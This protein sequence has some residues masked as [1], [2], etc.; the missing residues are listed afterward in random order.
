MQDLICGVSDA[1]FSATSSMLNCLL[2]GFTAASTS[3]HQQTGAGIVTAPSNQE[4]AAMARDILKTLKSEHAELRSLF[5]QMEDTTDRAAKKRTDILRKIEDGLIPHAKWEEL[6][7]YP[8][9]KARADRDGLKT[10]SEAVQEH[11][12]VEVTVLPDLKKKDPATPDFAG[13][14]KVLGEFVKHHAKEEE[15]TMFSDAREMFSKDELAQFDEHY[16]AWKKS[17]EGKQ[18][19]AAEKAKSSR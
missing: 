13:S 18:V 6:V 12:A 7:F 15:S 9:F 2:S 19:V 14:A 4:K 3:R 16:E 17:A 8:A 1:S 5:T 10:Y 11:R